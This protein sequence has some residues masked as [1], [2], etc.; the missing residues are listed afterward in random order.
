MTLGYDLGNLTH[1]YVSFTMDFILLLFL[2][3]VWRPLVLLLIYIELF[4]QILISIGRAIVIEIQ[5][6]TPLNCIS[7]AIFQS[8]NWSIVST[9]FIMIEKLLLFGLSKPSSQQL[10][11]CYDCF[12]CIFSLSL[13]T[14]FFIPFGTHMVLNKHN[15]LV[16][17]SFCYRFFHHMI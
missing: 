4:L 6:M 3:I 7:F 8:I 9:C 15:K 5:Y 12:Q 10:C 14:R 2:V 16:K 17:T 11:F 1:E 13:V